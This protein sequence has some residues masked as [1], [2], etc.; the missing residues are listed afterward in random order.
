MLGHNN[1]PPNPKET[2]NKNIERKIPIL[3][4]DPQFFQNVPIP[5]W[6]EL[7]LI[8][9]CNRSC[10][11]C[12][13]SDI[14]IAPDTYQKMEL[15]LI[16][17]LVDDLK[18]INFEGA[19]CLCGYGEP[20]LHKNL[21]EIVNKLGSLGGIEIITNGDLINEKTL[22]NLYKSKATRVLISLY[23]GPEQLIKFK[24]LIKKLNIPEDFVILRDRWY[25][26]KQDYGVK[27]TNRVGTV[28]VGNQ[29]K[30]NDYLNRKCF[31]TAY[32]TLI[33]WDGNMY[34]CPQDW[35]RKYAMGNIMQKDFFSIWN[36]KILS[37]YRKSLLNGDRNLPPCNKCNAEGIVYGAKHYQ[38]WQK[39][40]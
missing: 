10:S 1:P 38:A 29:P 7:S 26:D 3:N 17:K 12:P 23:D 25:S 13:K 35:Q 22:M 19:F 16:D 21:I 37:K 6:I 20:M 33:D 31:Y 5:S 34:L 8:D 4:R 9:V 15:S 32:Q 11:F 36:G 28:N 14:S 24:D 18:K 27:L 39:V 2:I 40:R 30:A